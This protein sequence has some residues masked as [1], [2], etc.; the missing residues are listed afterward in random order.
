MKKLIVAGALSVCS[1]A[2][3]NAADMYT[4]GPGGFKDAPYIESSWAGFYGGV[5]A[6]YAWGDNDISYYF[7][8]P[9]AG[10]T[11]STYR[12]DKVSPEGGYAGSLGGYN[13]QSGHFVY[14]LEADFDAGEV[15]GNTSKLNPANTWDT[16]GDKSQLDWWGT[17]RGRLGY[18]FGPALVYA[19]G[20]F[21]Y[22]LVESQVTYTSTYPQHCC[23]AP[24]GTVAYGRNNNS[25][26]LG[27][28]VVGG[29]VEYAI[30]PKWSLK[31]EY[32]F[33]DLGNS[34][35]GTNYCYA[36]CTT[37]ELH[38]KVDNS[39]NLVSVGVNYHVGGVF[40]PLK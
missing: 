31:G 39:F 24:A 19:T 36:G 3:A 38:A 37:N 23:G 13:W 18:T 29:G 21:A 30:N 25:E 8:D 32:Q 17:V 4:P 11:S 26:V 33:I 27:G 40:E 7:H 28:W 2:S 1:I 5:N 16:Y 9:V 34:D 20:G 10:T 12:F 22:G 35:V 14:G 6:G 15:S